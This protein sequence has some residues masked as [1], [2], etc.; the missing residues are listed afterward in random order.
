M[1]SLRRKYEIVREFGL[2]FPGGRLIEFIPQPYKLFNKI[3]HYEWGTRNDKAFIPKFLGQQAAPDT[4]YAELWIGSHPKAPSEIEIGSRRIPLNEVIAQHGHQCLG[5]Y[6]YDKFSGTLPFLLKVLS[7]A[8]AL[9]IQAHPNKSQAVKLHASHPEHY[10]DDNHKPEI[11]I[12]VD[13]LNALVG[14]KPAAEISRSLRSVPEIGEYADENIYARAAGGTGQDSLERAIRDLYADIMARG[15]DRERLSSC[16]RKIRERLLR[17]GA[18]S[19]EEEWFLAQYEIYGD[20]IGLLSFFFFNMVQLKPGQ[21]IFTDAGVPHA[22]IEGNIIECMANSDNVVRAGLTN[23]FKDV[24]TLLEIIRFEFSDGGIIDP[25]SRSDEVVYDTKAE[26]FRITRLLKKGGFRKVCKFNDR[27]SICLVAGGEIEVV[28]N[29]AGVDHLKS[30]SKGESFFL[31][32]FLE[33]FRISSENDSDCF[34][35][36]IP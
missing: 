23:K 13:S 6:V 31:P 4:P 33:E 35:V 28:W 24:A 15:E 21:A 16:V 29:H 7:A 25:D 18:R 20:D 17:K 9:S 5:R 30:F 22:Y 8:H 34:V 14:F 26:E 11:A 12:A 19:L 32:A 1:L 3:Q 27:P 10:P 2:S 36:R